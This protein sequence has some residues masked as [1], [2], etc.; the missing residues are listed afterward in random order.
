MYD[1]KLNVAEITASVQKSA[2]KQEWF[3]I[4]LKPVDDHSMEMILSWENTRTTVPI[5]ADQMDKTSRITEKL[6]EIRTIEREK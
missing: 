4:D 2:E 3:E 5:K 6:R 1:E